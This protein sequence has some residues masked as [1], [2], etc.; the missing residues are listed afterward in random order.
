MSLE[1]EPSVPLAPLTTLELGG[2][3]ELFASARTS[4]ECLEA[5]EYAEARGLDVTF[6]GGGS[7]VVVPDEGVAGLVVAVR[8]RGLH[9]ER[10]A[11]KSVT[12][13]A[14]A[15]EPWEGVVEAAV[16]RELAGL[17]CL[18]GIPGLTGATPIQNVGAYGQEVGDRL[19][20]V[21]VFDRLERRH[22]VLSRED[23]E[24]GYRDSRLKR[25]PTRFLVLSVSFEL[26]EGGAPS[27][28]YGEL[29]AACPEGASLAE[30]RRVVLALR[31]K[32]SMVIDPADP[33]RRSA[34]SFFTNPVVDAA[35]LARV[36]EIAK[37]R[38]LV[39]RG[40]EVPRYPAGD[41]FK[42]AAGWLIERAGISRGLRR[43]AVGVSDAH[44]LA[45]VHHGGGQTAELLALAAEIRAKV[46]A[47][48]GV[49]LEAEPRLFGPA[50]APALAP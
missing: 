47:V 46:E 28:R 40:D 38:G 14:L 20:E 26:E 17:E 49:R 18:T 2:H 34:G 1:L 13:R 23:C 44:S 9:F 39:S 31:R 30:V 50:G 10:G 19:V 33:N 32:K 4:A 48:F 21:E 8:S 3:A 16:S 25:D 35:T 29:T 12:L 36:V 42:L 41:A 5:L 6:L 24:L 37:T 15:G 27:L 7:N 11:G 45:L 22:R 43:G